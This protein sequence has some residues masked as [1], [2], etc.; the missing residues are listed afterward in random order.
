MCISNLLLKVQS[1]YQYIVDFLD[2]LNGKAKLNQQEENTEALFLH[3]ST[4][5][6]LKGKAL[7]IDPIVKVAI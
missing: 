3:F 4:L 6:W 5:N 2:S 1:K 7:H